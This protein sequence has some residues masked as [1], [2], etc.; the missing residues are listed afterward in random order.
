M[1]AIETRKLTKMF[2]GHVAV[3][4]LDL[5]VPQGS[6]FGFLGPNGAGKT[7]TLRM[8][9]GLARP[10]SG[11]AVVLGEPV[12]HPS[13]RYLS[14]TG[15]LPDVPG[16]YNWMRPVE[17]LKLIGE[18]FG[19]KGRD[20][21]LRIGEVLELTG[22][23]GVKTKIGG[24]SRGMKQRLGLAQALLN[25]PELI[26]LDE[27]TSALDPIG[28]KE[29]LDVMGRL[30][31]QTTIFFSTHILNDVERVCDTVA[32]LHQGKLLTQQRIHEL[33]ESYASRFLRIEVDGDPDLPAL[34]GDQ[35]WV[36][37]IER[38]GEGWRLQ[39]QDLKVAQLRL[40]EFL[41]AH[42]LALRR[43]EILEPSLEDIFVRLVNK[44]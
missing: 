19:L 31:G 23:V 3:D 12:S 26:F 18:I 34:L 22:L 27:P 16:F 10:T 39:A 11:L 24:F 35:P 14:R 28:R 44:K 9:V 13:R 33:R 37:Q 43:F 32:I 29:V 17:F 41:S 30:A 38:S 20:L 4:E 5:T 25:R 7:T 8:L 1:N 36:K 6:V 40:P 21:T 15:Y 42:G 2:N